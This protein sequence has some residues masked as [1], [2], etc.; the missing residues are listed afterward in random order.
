[1]SLVNF[2][3]KI[4][5]DTTEVN[6]G[7]KKVESAF[8]SLGSKIGSAIGPYLGA[9]AFVAFIRNAANAADAVGDLAEQANESTDNI[10][11]LQDLA[12]RSGVD[13]EKYITALVKLGETRNKALAGDEK[14]NLLFSRFGISSADLRSSKTNL[15]LLEQVGAEYKNQ[16]DSISAQADAADLLGAKMFKV[17]NTINGIKDAGAISLFTEEDVD[18]ASRFNDSLANITRHLGILGKGLVND[19]SDDLE[20]F[21]N[22]TGPRAIARMLGLFGPLRPDFFTN[23]LDAKGSPKPGDK[24]F[25]GPVNM[26]KEQQEADAKKSAEEIVAAR[27]GDQEWAD[28]RAIEIERTQENQKRKRDL[29]RDLDQAL[30]GTGF[31]VDSAVT[32]G[33]FF[34]GSDRQAQLGQ[35]MNA[36]RLRIEKLTEEIAEVNK[37]LE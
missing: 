17:L 18:K 22:T 8:A 32:H 14:S 20:M 34:G 25:I 9:A 29:Q 26:T 21:T 33:A 36:L 19:L 16:K 12:M 31:G 24:G 30:S 27:K 3:I 6:I 1:M 23:L 5:L 15:A 4:G 37:K 10:Q 28:K 13:V 2:L 35:G 11:R 7:T